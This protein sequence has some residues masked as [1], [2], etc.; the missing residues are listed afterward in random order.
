[1][2]GT[3]A[4]AE[5]AASL[6]AVRD[7]A[8]FLRDACAAAGVDEAT[9]IDLELAVVEAANNIVEHGALDPSRGTIGIEFSR[10]GEAACVVLSDGG[11]PVSGDLFSR[12]REVPPE[13]LSGRGIGIIRSCVDEIDYNC[14]DG[15]NRL[16]LVK[17][18]GAA[19]PAGI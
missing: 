11:V 8:A 5:V 1:M 19:R 10:D 16:R 18:I 4:R 15:I 3:I 13:A 7:L 17:H 14:C 6:I 2:A 12:C 9:A